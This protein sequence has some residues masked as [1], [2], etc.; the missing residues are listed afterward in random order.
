MTKVFAK[1]IEI[2]EKFSL[3]FERECECEI[4]VQSGNDFWENM[5]EFTYFLTKIQMPSHSTLT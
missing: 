1:M 2:G 4:F 5:V 3:T